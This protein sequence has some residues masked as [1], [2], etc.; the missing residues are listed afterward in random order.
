MNE[1]DA[2]LWNDDDDDDDDDPSERERERERE[3]ETLRTCGEIGGHS[4][5]LCHRRRS[6]L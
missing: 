4:R 2:H 1:T 5:V 6:H 3:R